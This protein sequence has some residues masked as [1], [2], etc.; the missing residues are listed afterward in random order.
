M[1]RA[2]DSLDNT[3]VMAAAQNGSKETFEAVMVSARD[4]LTEDEV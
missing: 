4:T 3:V 2:T 1:F